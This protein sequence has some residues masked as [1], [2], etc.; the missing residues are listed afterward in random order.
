MPALSRM[1]RGALAAV[2]LCISLPAFG[3]S[4]QETINQFTVKAEEF[5]ARDTTKAVTAEIGLLKAFL[6]EAQN[7][8]AQDEPEDLDLALARVRT[9]ADL[10]D[11]ELGRVE[12]ETVAT[13]AEARALAKEAELG[14][15]NTEIKALEKERAAIEAGGAH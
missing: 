7:Y 12:A 5:T 2:V 3:A 9:A 1:S 4:K 10:I 6:A 13:A 15:L 14:K 8:L 11:A